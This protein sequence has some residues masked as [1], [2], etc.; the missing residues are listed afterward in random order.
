MFWLV[1]VSL[2]TPLHNLVQPALYTHLLVMLLKKNP[3]AFEPEGMHMEIWKPEGMHME[4]WSR[5]SNEKKYNGGKYY[6]LHT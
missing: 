1:L 6:C 4:I 2:P 3:T 5:G